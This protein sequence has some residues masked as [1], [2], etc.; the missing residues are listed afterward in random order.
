MPFISKKEYDY[1]KAENDYL[2]AENSCLNE[3][4]KYSRRGKIAVEIDGKEYFNVLKTSSNLFDEDGEVK[5]FTVGFMVS[6]SNSSI[7]EY[8]RNFLMSVMHNCNCYV[9]ALTSCENAKKL[10]SRK[11]DKV[12]CKISER[13]F[14]FE[15]YRCTLC[16]EK[17]FFDGDVFIKEVNLLEDWYHIVL[18]FVF[19]VE[20]KQ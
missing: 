11:G 15:E 13:K 2:K 12:H 8:P 6:N 18:G 19:E 7:K 9:D 10:M 5:E 14:K 3:I 16:E 20:K 1:L 17:I 4:V